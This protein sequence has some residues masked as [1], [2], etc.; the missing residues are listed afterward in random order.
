MKLKQPIPVTAFLLNVLNTMPTM[1]YSPTGQ[2]I[3]FIIGK[4]VHVL[5]ATAESCKI[6]G[7]VE[8]SVACSGKY[9][10]LHTLLRHF[11]ELPDGVR[12]VN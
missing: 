1:D 7:Q 8:L 12:F 9:I 2:A 10:P 3:E 11:F 6:V 4:S 5:F